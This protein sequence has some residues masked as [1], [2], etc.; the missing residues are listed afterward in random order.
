MQQRTPMLLRALGW[1]VFLEPTVVLNAVFQAEGFATPTHETIGEFLV[2]VVEVC[3][4]VESVADGAF[5]ERDE[6][7]KHD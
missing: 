5:D 7:I 2:H 1:V 6:V 4:E 3:E